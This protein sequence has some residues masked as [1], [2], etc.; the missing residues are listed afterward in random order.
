MVATL[1]LV[2]PRLSVLA[3]PGSQAR[4]SKGLP[5]A[6]HVLTVSDPRLLQ[7]ERTDRIPRL[8]A[9]VICRI[10]EPCMITHSY[11]MTQVV[12]GQLPNRNTRD[13]T[14]IK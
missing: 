8:Q 5:L 3:G 14:S 12:K 2:H 9:W 7:L 10:P 6:L 1:L 4:E 11:K 13:S